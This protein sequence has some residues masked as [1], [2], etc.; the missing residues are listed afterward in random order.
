MI[1]CSTF[2]IFLGS[3]DL[4]SNAATIG[5][6]SSKVQQQ[7]TAGIASTRAYVRA[8]GGFRLFAFTPSL[9][10]RISLETSILRVKVSLLPKTDYLSFIQR[11]RGEGSYL[12]LGMRGGRAAARQKRRCKMP[13]ATAARRV[14]A[15]GEKSTPFAFTRNTLCNKRLQR[16]L[17]RICKT[18]PSPA[19]F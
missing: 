16:I 5:S 2:A 10:G 18:N 7:P 9:L 14:K 6:T 13:L 8:S 3:P 17:T 19:I 1:G 11:L 4:R 12:H 15:R